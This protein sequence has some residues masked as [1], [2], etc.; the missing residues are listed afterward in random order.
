M[1]FWVK[2][3]KLYLELPQNGRAIVPRQGHLVESHNV[4]GAA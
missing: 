4:E 2:L 3:A 1:K